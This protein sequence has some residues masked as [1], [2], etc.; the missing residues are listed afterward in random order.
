MN[1]I[2]ATIGSELTLSIG[3]TPDFNSGS[4]RVSPVAVVTIQDHLRTPSGD[5][6]HQGL[7]YKLVSGPCA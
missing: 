4:N 6:H 3:A 1:G 5:D 7:I 2:W